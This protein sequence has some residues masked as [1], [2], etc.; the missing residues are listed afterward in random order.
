M[1]LRQPAVM[2]Q[3][4]IVTERRL[5]VSLW[6]AV[7]G[8][9]A[10]VAPA[11]AQWPQFRGPNGSGV[12]S[13]AGYP[14]TFSPTTHMAWK[15]QVPYGQSSPVIYGSHVYVTASEGNRLLTM[16]L[17]ATTGRELWRRDI[18][19]PRSQNAFR[20]NDP[21]SPTP[22]ADDAGVIVFLRTSAWPPTRRTARTAGRSRLARS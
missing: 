8:L 4:A 6:L 3:G 17:D 12:A 14:I 21:A 20:A 1:L 22:A 5:A 19:A 10:G 15:T 2:Q 16:C 18:V 7:A 9:L 13:G 11:A